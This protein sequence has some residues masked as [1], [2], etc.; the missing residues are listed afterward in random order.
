MSALLLILLGVLLLLWLAGAYAVMFNPEQID[1][2]EM[3]NIAKRHGRPSK[4]YTKDML[5]R[6]DPESYYYSPR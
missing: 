2:E 3:V 6:A 5:E 1:E 4:T